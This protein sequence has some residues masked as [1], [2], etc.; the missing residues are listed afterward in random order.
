VFF[1]RYALGKYV[2]QVF[3]CA[4]LFRANLIATRKAW[5]KVVEQ[6]KWLLWFFHL[7][8]FA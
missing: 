8:L 4:T 1:P 6:N 2:P 3:F 5:L 7:W